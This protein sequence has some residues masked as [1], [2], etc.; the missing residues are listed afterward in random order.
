MAAKNKNTKK[1]AKKVD[2]KDEQK[3]V[4]TPTLVE[5][6]EQHRKAEAKRALLATKPFAAVTEPADE[7]GIIAALRERIVE[8]N[9]LV[10]E[11]NEKIEDLEE[12]V[13]DLEEEIEE[14]DA[15]KAAHVAAHNKE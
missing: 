2:K 1:V 12:K 8:L 13:E 14:R 15:L 4:R 5:L 9:A 11:L 3:V 6:N 10:D 7:D